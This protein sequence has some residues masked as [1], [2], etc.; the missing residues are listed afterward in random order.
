MKSQKLKTA[1]KTAAE[2]K[3]ARFALKAAWDAKVAADEAWKAANRAALDATLK[4]AQ[5]ADAANAE[6]KALLKG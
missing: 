1:L 5:A 4:A 3:D 2:A 6:W